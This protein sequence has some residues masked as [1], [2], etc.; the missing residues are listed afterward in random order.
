M[1]Y[2]ILGLKSTLHTSASSYITWA[3]RE[4]RPLFCVT[5]PK[6]RRWS[7]N[8]WVRGREGAQAGSAF[9][10]TTVPNLSDFQKALKSCNKFV[11]EKLHPDG[12]Q[13]KH[14]FRREM[15]SRSKCAHTGQGTQIK[16]WH[17]SPQVTPPLTERFL[18]GVLPTVWC[19]FPILKQSK[20]SGTRARKA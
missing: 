8:C 16:P 15:G 12:V 3:S 1:F 18:A 7:P 19:V 4:K 13:T 14:V 17:M 2:K 6:E 20:D 5:E 9:P 10:H 11:E